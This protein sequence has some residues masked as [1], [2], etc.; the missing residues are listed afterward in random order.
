MNW[1]D[2]ADTAIK[3]GLGALIAG[4]FS[5]IASKVRHNQETIVSR[6]EHLRRVLEDV[7]KDLEST[8]SIL[9][10]K[11]TEEARYW[12]E[13]LS[14]GISIDEEEEW[15]E[16]NRDY[17]KTVDSAI[18]SLGILDGK[19]RLYALESSAEKL[20]TLIDLLDSL[21]EKVSPMESCVDTTFDKKIRDIFTEIGKMKSMF[22]NELN[23]EAIRRS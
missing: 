4:V 18:A 15:W 6:E 12:E 8:L 21:P 20:S 2:V 1:I 17:Q 7:S 5:L 23:K 16:R 19:L 22:Y 3:I 14:I 9:F 10:S 11:G 13:R